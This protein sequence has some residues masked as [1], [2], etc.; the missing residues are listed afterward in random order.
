MSATNSPV[1]TITLKCGIKILDGREIGVGVNIS[2]QVSDFFELAYT[3]S[4]GFY[5]IVFGC[6][7]AIDL[8]EKYIQD[9]KMITAAL[10]EANKKVL[11]LKQ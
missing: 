1:K 9:F 10:K 4:S 8:S 11:N 3:K 2:N 6:N 7:L 5:I